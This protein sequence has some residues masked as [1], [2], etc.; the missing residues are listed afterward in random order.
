[1]TKCSVGSTRNRSAGSKRLAPRAA[2][3]AH[4][5]AL[6]SGS[7]SAPGRRRFTGDAR[8]DDAHDERGHTKEA[9]ADEKQSIRVDERAARGE[10]LDPHAGESFRKLPDVRVRGAQKRV[11]GRSIAKTRQA[12]HVG[13]QRDARE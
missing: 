11:L 7:S 4:S 9:R 6:T 3:A 1:M 8:K 13:H 5:S 12:G 2:D 10:A